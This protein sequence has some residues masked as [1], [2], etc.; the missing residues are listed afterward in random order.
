MWVIGRPRQRLRSCAKQVDEIEAATN[1]LQE[2]CAELVGHVIGGN[3]FDKIGITGDAIGL[4]Q[5]SWNDD[6]QQIYGR[7]DLSIGRDGSIKMLEYNADTPTSLLEASVV[8]WQWLESV[9]PTAD[10]FNSIHERLIEAWKTSGLTGLV[11]FTC[12]EDSS[13]DIITV[14][15]LED[16]ARQAGL[17]TKFVCLEDIGLSDKTILRK[18]RFADLDNWEIKNCF[19]LYPWEWLTGDEF[20]PAIKPSGIR[21]IEPAWKMILS[22][23]A[24]L[25]LLYDMFPDSPYLLSTTFAQQQGE[26]WVRKPFLSREGANI[27]IGTAAETPGEYGGDYIFQKYH[28][29]ITFPDGAK[30]VTPIIGSWVIAEES[31]GI[32]IR[33]DNGVTT[34]MARFVPHYFK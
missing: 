28:E 20:G 5:D 13:E 32:G 31:A 23:K 24:M 2:M 16:T 25:P 9:C 34:N 10:Q 21:F 14:A 17:Q 1:R 18:Q 3:Q 11:H 7:F 33:E 12:S 27:K 4:I 26:G 15:Y 29:T 30:E 6:E 8:Q 22:N 19:K